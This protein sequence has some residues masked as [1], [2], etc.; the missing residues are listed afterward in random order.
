MKSRKLTLTADSEIIAKAKELAAESNSSVSSM[1]S[2]FI[3][4]ISR[5]PRRKEKFDVA[6][7]TQRATGLL[8]LERHADERELLEDA[9]L[10]K[11]TGGG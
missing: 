7:I 1:F 9:L 5:K 10:E 4:S 6:P 8:T 2:R 11:Y 3:A